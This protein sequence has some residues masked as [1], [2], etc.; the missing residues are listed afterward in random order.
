MKKL[1]RVVIR[2]SDLIESSPVR[3]SSNTN[4]ALEAAS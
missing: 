1:E 3:V 4:R 2:I